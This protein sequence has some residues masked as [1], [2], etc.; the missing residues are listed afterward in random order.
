[1]DSDTWNSLT[2]A[3]QNARLDGAASDPPPGTHSNFDNPVNHGDIAYG[4][5]IALT[6]LTAIFC[7]IRFYSR[8]FVMRRV[9]GPDVLAL[10]SFGAYIGAIWSIL[11]PLH[12]GAFYVHQWDL[13]LRVFL[14][15]IYAYALL[16]TFYS[17]CMLFAKTAIL[18]EW[19]QIFVP[20]GTRGFFFWTCWTVLVLNAAFYVSSIFVVNFSCRPAKKAWIPWEPGYCFNR[21]YFDFSTACINLLLDLIIFLVPQRIIWRL[22]MSLKQKAQISLL[23]SIGLLTIVAAISR[24]VTGT[25]LIDSVDKTWDTAPPGL[26]AVA[27]MTGALLIFCV[28]AVPKAFG[29]S[30]LLPKIAISLKTWTRRGFL[31]RSANSDGSGRSRSRSRM[32]MPKPKPSPYDKAYEVP[33]V[34]LADL[35]SLNRPQTSY[36]STRDLNRRGSNST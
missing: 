18:K 32:P 16:P 23:F 31:S 5:T 35:E 30:T 21:R 8:V 6:I 20:N 27:E 19:L 13:R 26:C 12:M 1:M 2:P 22:N 11:L 4:V 7:L 34:A 24:V 33:Q 14:D 9:S 28:P 25:E 29:H 17:G 3:E 15:A 10:V 36:S